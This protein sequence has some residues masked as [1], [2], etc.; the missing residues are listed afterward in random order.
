[1]FGVTR[2]WD[3]PHPWH[4]APRSERG[5]KCG[6]ARRFGTLPDTGRWV[7]ADPVSGSSTTLDPV[8][9]AAGLR[10]RLEPVVEDPPD[11]RAATLRA[12][13]PGLERGDRERLDAVLEGAR[14]DGAG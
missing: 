6:M 9:G 14:R 2:S 10:R 4:A 8:G 11:A 3:A 12:L 5:V 1:M 7:R 13:G